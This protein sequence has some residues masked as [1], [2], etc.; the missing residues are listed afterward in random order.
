MFPTKVNRRP[1]HQRGRER[2]TWR[3]GFGRNGAGRRRAPTGRGGL[4]GQGRRVIDFGAVSG[5]VCDVRDRLPDKTKEI[6]PINR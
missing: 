3:I 4:A 5:G 1:T 2:R 6:A